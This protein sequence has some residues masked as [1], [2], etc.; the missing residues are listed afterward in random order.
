[1]RLLV[2]FALLLGCAGRPVKMKEKLSYVEVL[3]RG[4]LVDVREKDEVDEGAI[5]GSYWIPLSEAK[6]NPVEARNS[7]KRIAEGKEVF[8]Y[9]RSG[10]RSQEFIEILGDKFGS[11]NLGGYE[12]LLE[13]G[14][15]KGDFKSPSLTPK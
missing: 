11:T 15:P 5:K 9:C 7:V 8:A 10:R 2:L 3:K 14:Y 4:V 13:R 1:M 12:D 6:I